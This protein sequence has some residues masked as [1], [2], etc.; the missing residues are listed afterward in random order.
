MTLPLVLAALLAVAVVV[1][2]AW[3]FLSAPDARGDRLPEP[4]EGGRLA[5]A[6]ERD[7]ALDAVRELEFDH[8]TGKVSDEDYRRQIGP[9]RRRAAELLRASD[10][11]PRTAGDRGGG[12]TERS[13]SARARQ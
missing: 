8:R 7:R 2:V 6:E 10:P 1:F 13:V 9:L 3:P 5:L 12:E 4:R 11:A